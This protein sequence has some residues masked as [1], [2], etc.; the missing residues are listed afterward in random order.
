MSDNEV[1]YN[2]KDAVATITVNRPDKYNALNRTVKKTLRN[3]FQ[4]ADEDISVRAVI[5]TGTGEKAFISG[6]D[7]NNFVGKDSKTIRPGVESSRDISRYIESMSKPTIAAVNGYALGGGCEL[8]MACD[9]RYASRNARFGL[10]EINLGTIPGNGGTARLPRIVGLGIAKEMVLTGELISAED[11]FRIGLVN[12]IFE[13]V[14]A[15]REGV[16]ELAAKLV[17]KPRV[18]VWLANESL[19]KAWQ[20]SLDEHLKHELDAFCQTFDLHTPSKV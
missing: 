19:D 13:S 1:L 2:A 7:I 15:L 12:K 3:M 8:A 6:A 10:P 5:L 20:V 11:S 18:A 9:I 4:Q 16:F 14:D 17:S